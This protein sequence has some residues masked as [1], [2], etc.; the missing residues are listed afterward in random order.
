MT[1]VPE[2][3]IS[4]V[5]GDVDGSDREIELQ[6]AARPRP[7]ED[8]S[9]PLAIVRPTVFLREG[10]D[11]ASPLPDLLFKKEVPPV[12]APRDAERLRTRG[13][14]ARSSCLSLNAPLRVRTGTASSGLAFDQAVKMPP[15][16]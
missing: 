5:S 2:R 6:Q 8:D 10:L 13:S 16:E 4:F 9:Q 15:E 1:L 12:A 7:I 3:R 14:T 11:L